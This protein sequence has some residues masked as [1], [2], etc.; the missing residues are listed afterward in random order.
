MLSSLVVTRLRKAEKEAAIQAKRQEVEALRRALEKS[1]QP[2]QAT[3]TAPISGGMFGLTDGASE[4]PQGS[5]VSDLSS[6]PPS[7]RRSAQGYRQQQPPRATVDRSLVETSST[8]D[9]DIEQAKPEGNA[10]PKSLAMARSPPLLLG[11][12]APHVKLTDQQ[13]QGDHCKLPNSRNSSIDRSQLR[14]P[15]A[16]V[17]P[18]LS[19][20]T[21]EGEEGW[22]CWSDDGGGAAGKTEKGELLSD[23][24]SKG[25]E[26]APRAR[27]RENSAR[28]RPALQVPGH[29]DPDGAMISDNPLHR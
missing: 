23:R 22:R 6:G 4:V 10:A 24:P 1:S 20:Q 5:E 28:D 8:C 15:V 17:S 9:G 26:D 11:S 19:A 2:P 16:G 7:F 21:P 3:L 14:P 25:R 13:S 29:T 27:G 18:Q 12:P